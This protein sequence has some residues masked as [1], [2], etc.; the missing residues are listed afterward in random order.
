[1]D[2]RLD[3]NEAELGVPILAVAL[4]V[5]P[6]GHSLLNEV[7]EVLGDVR[8]ESCP[9]SIQKIDSAQRLLLGSGYG[10]WLLLLAAADRGGGARGRP[11]HTGLGYWCDLRGIV[12]Q[13]ARRQDRGA[14]RCP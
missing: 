10:C 14:H 2:A 3:E 11:T 6:H 7:V 4:Q 1:V 13:A 8:G 9:Q 12:A 5:L